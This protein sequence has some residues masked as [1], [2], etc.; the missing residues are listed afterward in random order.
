MTR[1]PARATAVLAAGLL[2][3][4]CSLLSY[5]A[6]TPAPPSQPAHAT[7]P[8][9]PPPATAPPALASILPF[10]PARLQA[11]AALAARFTVAWDSWSWQQS[12]AAWLA[13]LRPMAASSLYRALAQAAGTPGVLARRHADRQSAAATTS[14][15][16]IRDLT[17]GSVTVTVTIRQVI[18]SSAGTSHATASFAVTLTPRGGDWAIWDIE[19]AGAGNN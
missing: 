8:A 11:A 19:P 14:E 10:P 9:G 7:G 12:P 2:C 15:L 17:P 4:G 3:A 16:Q 13:R 5:P 18:T 1:R 6:A